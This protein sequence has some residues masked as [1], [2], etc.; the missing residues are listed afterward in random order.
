MNRVMMDVFPTACSPRNTS[1][2]LLSLF[3]SDIGDWEHEGH[4]KKL[5][6]QVANVNKALGAV[7]YLVDNGYRVVF[8]K[9]PESGKDISHMFDKEKKTA[10]RFRREKNI[11][12]LDTF[13]SLADTS[14]PFHRHA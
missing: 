14:A 13:V 12:K 6:F 7:S 2:Y 3:F 1:L 11:W 4:K 10:S 5:V 8:D 9:D